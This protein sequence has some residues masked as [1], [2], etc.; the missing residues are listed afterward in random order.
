MTS[1][2]RTEPVLVVS[3]LDPRLTAI[4]IE[5][6]FGRYGKV[7]KVKE[8]SMKYKPDELA[9]RVEFDRPAHATTAKEGLHGK[10]ALS[11]KLVVEYEVETFREPDSQAI[12]AIEEKLKKIEK[13]VEVADEVGAKGYSRNTVVFNKKGLGTAIW[14]GLGVTKTRQCPT[15]FVTNIPRGRMSDLEA[16]FKDDPGFDGVRSMRHMAFV[17]Y[18]S[19]SFATKGMI[20]H[21]NERMPGLPRSHG[22][23]V[24]DFDRDTR[25]KRNRAYEKARQ[26]KKLLS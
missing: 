12:S 13:G 7:L 14:N 23:L 9:F 2:I 1:C 25:A 21:Q 19:I 20:K 24:I 18:K 4:H 10:V 3:N 11:K 6:L 5:K 16:V 26:R 22:G 17:D 8:T 15:L